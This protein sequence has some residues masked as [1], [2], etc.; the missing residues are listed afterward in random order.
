MVGGEGKTIADVARGH[1]NLVSLGHLSDPVQM[2]PHHQKAQIAPIPTLF[3][4]W[5][6]LSVAL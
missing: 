4:P 1:L 5:Q 6:L 2:A 3:K